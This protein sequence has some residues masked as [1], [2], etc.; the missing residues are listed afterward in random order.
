MFFDRV[1][2]SI[3]DKFFDMKQLIRYGL[4]GVTSNVIAYVIYLL[5]TYLGVEPKITMSMMYLTGASIGFIGNR[6]WTFSHEGTMWKSLIR[7]GTAHFFGYLMNLSLLLLFVDE[8]GYPHQWVQAAAVV[9]V[10]GFLFAAFKYFVFPKG[11][12]SVGERA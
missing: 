9:L 7:Y 6:K 3:P 11:E 10:A 4:L 2:F 8:L 12:D 1:F 5:I